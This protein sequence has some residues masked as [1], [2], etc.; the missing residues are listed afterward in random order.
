[1]AFVTE[2]QRIRAQVRMREFWSQF[3]V[4][5]MVSPREA[6]RLLAQ[7]RPTL[8]GKRVAHETAESRH[9]GR[10]KVNE[11]PVDM[12]G[13][14]RVDADTPVKGRNKTRRKT[15]KKV[16][17]APQRQ[18]AA[19]DQVGLNG[20]SLV[21]PGVSPGGYVPSTSGAWSGNS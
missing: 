12:F 7:E 20:E 3:V 15:S 19:D 16:P 10:G 6:K 1:M 18:P 8:E 5:K 11:V 21:L 2:E 9:D 14:D 17:Q 13:M 4:K